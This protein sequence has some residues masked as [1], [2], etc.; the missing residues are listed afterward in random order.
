MLL[1]YFRLQTDFKW[2]LILFSFLE[3]YLKKETQDR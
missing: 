1:C 3:I 2:N